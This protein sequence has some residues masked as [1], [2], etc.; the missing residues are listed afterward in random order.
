METDKNRFG[1]ACNYRA[2]SF[3]NN[4]PIVDAT[5]YATTRKRV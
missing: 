5:V 1:G 2:Y 4:D 3:V